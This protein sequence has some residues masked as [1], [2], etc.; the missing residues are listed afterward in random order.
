MRYDIWQ[1]QFKTFLKLR[2]NAR[3]AIQASITNLQEQ[4][5]HSNDEDERR[6]LNDSITELRSKIT[7]L[8][9][10]SI[11]ELNDSENV[12]QAIVELEELTN[13]LNDESSKTGE[14]ANSIQKG[15]AMVDKATKIVRKIAELSRFA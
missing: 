10:Q 5:N 14:V 15:V 8:R 9:E 4:F 3:K 13:N 1:T 2:I 6:Q 7:S 12:R 11:Q